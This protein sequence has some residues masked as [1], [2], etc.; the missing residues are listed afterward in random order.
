MFHK[1]KADAIHNPA[2]AEPALT[3]LDEITNGDIALGFA[4]LVSFASPRDNLRYLTLPRPTEGLEYGLRDWVGGSWRYR[5][6]TVFLSDSHVLF[7]I[8]RHALAI[9]R[10]M[11]DKLHLYPCLFALKS[12]HHLV[13]ANLPVRLQYRRLRLLYRPAAHV[14][15]AGFAEAN[16]T[17]PE[18]N[19]AAYGFEAEAARSGLAA[20][21]AA[22]TDALDAVPA[23]EGEVPGLF[24]IVPGV[25]FNELATR[26]RLQ[27]I[28]GVLQLAGP[29]KS[30]K[31]GLPRLR[32]DGEPPRLSVQV[33]F[34]GTVGERIDLAAAKRFINTDL[35]NP[36]EAYL[37]APLGD[38]QAIDSWSADTIYPGIYNGTVK[39]NVSEARRPSAHQMLSLMGQL[40]F[41]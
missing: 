17:K 6:K 13:E 39:V 8:K 25:T 2:F 19:P 16:L 36:D 23:E 10:I 7:S 3:M 30:I 41:C 29:L 1:I 11:D 26:L 9:A 21:L 34:A 35:Q 4:Q 14:T 12:D 40:G 5:A 28:A 15:D 31:V 20:E 18:I 37:T 22:W 38:W 24:Q 27:H 32:Q 33:S